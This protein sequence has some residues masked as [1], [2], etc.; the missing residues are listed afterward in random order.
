M[1]AENPDNYLSPK[2]SRQKKGRVKK[3]IA[4]AAP[5]LAAALGGPLAGAAGEY[6][7][8]HIAGP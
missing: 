8:A 2:K 5:K 4:Q 6:V 3:A 1:N 7:I